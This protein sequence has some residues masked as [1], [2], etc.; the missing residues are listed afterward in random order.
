MREAEA[1]L[2]AVEAELRAREEERQR[3][4]YQDRGGVEVRDLIRRLQGSTSDETYKLRVQ[5]AARLQSLVASLTVAPHGRSPLIMRAIEAL[6]DEHRDV[7]EHLRR[8]LDDW[9]T[10]RRYFAIQFRSGATRVVYAY[11]DPTKYD[12]QLV[13]T[14]GEGITRLRENETDEVVL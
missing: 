8:Q 10:Q 9:T 5:V 3:L 1:R 6:G 12:E 13:A 11:D 14:P 2:T 7:A 4:M